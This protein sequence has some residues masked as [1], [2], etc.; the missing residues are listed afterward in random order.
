[1]FLEIIFNLGRCILVHHNAL[2]SLRDRG[3]MFPSFSA[4]ALGDYFIRYSDEYDEKYYDGQLGDILFARLLHKN[5]KVRREVIKGIA[6][7]DVTKMFY[8]KKAMYQTLKQFGE[9]FIEPKKH[10]EVCKS[11]KKLLVKLLKPVKLSP[12][13]V[14]EGMD[15]H[16]NIKNFNTSAGSLAYGKKKGEVKELMIA[17]CLKY[18]RDLSLKPLPA[19]G[20]R[21]SQLG[22]LVDEKGNFNPKNV[23]KKGRL[24]WCL[25]AGQ[26]LFESQYARPLSDYLASMFPSIA[27]GKD[28]ATITKL[29]LRWNHKPYWISIDYSKFDSTIQ[30]WVIKEVFDIIKMFFDA[31][32][33]AELNWIRD[34]FIN[35]PIIMP[36]G[37][38]V[39]ARKGIKS[40]SYFTQVV[41]SLANAYMMLSF[42]MHKHKCSEH[43][44]LRDLF[45]VENPTHAT[46]MCMGD[47]NI[48]FT[49]NQIKTNELSVFMKK[50]FGIEVSKDKCDE[51][52]DE[53]GNAKSYPSFLKRTW[54]PLGADRPIVDLILNMMHPEREREYAKKGFSPWHVLYGYF[55]TYRVPFSKLINE[56]EI[57]K[58]MHEDGG[59]NRLLNIE[60]HDLPGSLGSFVNQDRLSWIMYVK[61]KAAAFGEDV[62]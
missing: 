22:S 5:R 9:N 6:H 27:T 61:D 41:G 7:Q 54:T 47:D 35:L 25:E 21:R 23:K 11:A 2:S 1:M 36:D 51:K 38:V 58:G 19:M 40:G 17:Q 62:A 31:Q 48:I 16:L 8:D 10:F 44:V 4:D 34:N 43:A 12:L 59:I 20:M 14:T 57:L 39:W 28:P 56:Y 15:L 13:T 46:F 37:E 53:N 50:T 26:I 30:S 18:K 33:H 24:V 45:S 55:I 52:Y 42:M 60:P 29:M 49:Y 3:V 32:Y